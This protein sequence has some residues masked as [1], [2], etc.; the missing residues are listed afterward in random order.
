MADETQKPTGASGEFAKYFVKL[1]L[2][3]D[4][5][6]LSELPKKLGP[7]EQKL[8]AFSKEGDIKNTAWGKFLGSG[9]KLSKMLDKV[10][11]D[12]LRFIKTLQAVGSA[13]KEGADGGAFYSEQLGFMGKRLVDV[14]K[15]FMD[16]GSSSEIAGT[17]IEGA[18]TAATLGIAALIIVVEELLKLFA[19]FVT[20]GISIQNTLNQYNRVFGGRTLEDQRKF[21]DTLMGT[22]KGLQSY[23]L[24]VGMVNEAVMSYLANG[25]AP[26][27]ALNKELIA[28]T[29]QLSYLLSPD[30]KLNTGVVD[31][32]SNLLKGTQA[33]TS[34]M[35]D[36]GNNFASFN[37][38][39]DVTGDLGPVSFDKLKE[40][41]QGSGTAFVIAASKGRKA[42]SE[43]SKDLMGLTALSNNLGIS[44]G[45]MAAKFE[46]AANLLSSPDS[47]FR[48]LLAISGGA[49]ISNLL[50]NQFNRTEATLAV[51]QQLKSL[52]A[53]FGGN[54]NILGQVAESQFGLSK[55]VAIK[56]VQTSTQTI[57]SLRKAQAFAETLNY[58]ALN[59]STESVRG[60]ITE[61][62]DKIK[63]VFETFVY[64]ILGNQQLQTVLGRIGI[65]LERFATDLGS[66]NGPLSVLV[67]KVTNV[68][69]TMFEWVEQNIIPKL[70]SFMEWIGNLANGN[71]GIWQ[72]LKDGAMDL[73]KMMGGAILEGFLGAMPGWLK[74][75]AI[76]AAIFPVVGPLLGAAIGAIVDSATGPTADAIAEGEKLRDSWGKV[77][78][79][80][81][82]DVKKKQKE[83]MDQKSALSGA[84]DTDV[85][86]KRNSQTGAAEFELAGLEKLNLDKE[87]RDV[88]E[89]L[90]TQTELNTKAME[91]LTRVM[92]GKG[93]FSDVS[94]VTE[95]AG[96]TNTAKYVVPPQTAVTTR[97]APQIGGVSGRFGNADSSA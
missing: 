66:E 58:D 44:V 69:S 97:Q 96:Q 43:L 5:K 19:G 39:L 8:Q 38:A 67:D 1:G 88:Q 51:V 52:N 87:L 93:S 21:N 79:S 56:L 10:G 12:N 24:G 25:L 31:L 81:L 75:G 26:N 72:S 42:A 92:Q 4:E 55:D 80:Q 30:G 61:A 59:K 76:G 70:Q 86:I 60:T 65:M 53:Q 63:K 32:F 74:G 68:I 20:A 23:G 27:V 85:I 57:D 62:W 77:L 28:T 9:D 18:L 73:A 16:V 90:T 84:Q 37:K 7:I 13:S 89:K 48:N 45:E 54:L 47:A 78:N 94:T 95:R 15:F 36:L 11:G 50:N 82:E 40:A 29:G 3:F 64:R 2:Q 6:E 22:I 17:M 83:L 34:W 33:Q 46:D 71:K 49:N 41:I 14:S 91:A 35:R